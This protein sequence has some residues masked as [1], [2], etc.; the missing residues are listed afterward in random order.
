MQFSS[1]YWH[2]FSFTQLTFTN[3][4]LLHK[5]YQFFIS[6][7]WDE[8]RMIRFPLQLLY[9]SNFHRHVFCCA[10]FSVRHFRLSYTTQAAAKSVPLK[11]FLPPR[12]LTERKF[13]ASCTHWRMD[14]SSVFSHSPRMQPFWAARRAHLQNDHS[15]VL[16]SAQTVPIVIN[17]NANVCFIHHRMLFMSSVPISL[18]WCGTRCK[19]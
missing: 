9:P 3:G 8:A 2:E 11:A 18:P 15:Q 7:S 17:I 4:K 10:A 6:S 1:Y 14:D 5:K 13:L 16:C 12:C 19:A